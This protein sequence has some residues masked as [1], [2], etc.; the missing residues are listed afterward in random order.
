MPDTAG[1]FW[2]ITSYYNPLGYRRRRANYR[3]FRRHLAIPLLTVELAYGAPEL[4]EADADRYVG[5]RGGA[6]LW[7]K[8]RLLNVA[9]SGRLR[10]PDPARVLDL[11]VVIAG[12][13]GDVVEQEERDRLGDPRAVALVP[14][15]HVAEL[16]AHGRVDTGLLADLAQ[17]GVG[18]R[19]A[20]LGVALGQRQD[21][22]TAGSAPHGD[23]HDAVRPAHD[24]S[25]AGELPLDR[26]QNT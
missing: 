3:T 23:D 2:A 20:G 17:R 14:V 26:H 1:D 11:V 8:E 6:L 21:L 25:S 16:L 5:L 7:Q 4:S 10:Q 15:A 12:L 13:A 19:L 18:G 9:M 22:A 24:H